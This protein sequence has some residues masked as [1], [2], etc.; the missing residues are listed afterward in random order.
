M[1]GRHLLT[2]R[3]IFLNGGLSVIL[4]GIMSV[5]LFFVRKARF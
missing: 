1:P 3:V 2:G 4:D 5:L